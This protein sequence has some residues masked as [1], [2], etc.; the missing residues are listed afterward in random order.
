MGDK[1]GLRE[2]R[3]GFGA[4]RAV[5]SLQDAKNKFSAVVEAARRDGPQTVTKRGEPAV[6]V[7]A[8]E[9]YERLKKLENERKPSLAEFLLNYPKFDGELEIDR[10]PIKMRDIEF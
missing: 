2:T 8:A 4:R 10:T 9:E 6:V 7:V 3:K 5:W 1:S